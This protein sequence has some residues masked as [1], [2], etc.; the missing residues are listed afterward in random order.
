M[1]RGEYQ[2]SICPYGY[3][4]GADGHMEPDEEAAA[5]V[6]L[7]FELAASGLNSGDITRELCRR[8]IMT[9]GQYKSQ[10]GARAYDVSRSQG[11]WHSSTVLNILKD[12]RYTGAYVL[13]KQAVLEVG[14]KNSVRKIGASGM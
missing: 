14:R 12:E 7:I 1:E 5:V 8:K 11:I 9:P 13:G 2:S 6:K 4:K 10:R 3:K